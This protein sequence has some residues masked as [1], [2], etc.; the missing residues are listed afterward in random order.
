MHDLIVIGSGGA[1]LAA[2]LTAASCGSK[3]LALEASSRWGGST[4]VSAGEV[5]VPANH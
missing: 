3:V 1:G 2:A 4:S 5:W